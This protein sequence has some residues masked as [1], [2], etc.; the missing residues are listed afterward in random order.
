M[1]L[2]LNQLTADLRAILDLAQRE[3]AYRHAPYVDVEHL[4]LGLFKYPAGTA[5]ALFEQ[6]GADSAALYT[7]IAGAVG[8]ERDKPVAI[9]GYTK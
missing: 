2:Q 6:Y 8:M 7:Q 5:H 3:A 1:Q 4:A 9:K